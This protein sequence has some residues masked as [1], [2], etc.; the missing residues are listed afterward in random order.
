MVPIRYVLPSVALRVWNSRQ[1]A[2]NVVDVLVLIRTTRID[3]LVEGNLR[4]RT[5]ILITV[6]VPNALTLVMST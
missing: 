1:I 6:G 3:S 5:K 4:A 2:Q